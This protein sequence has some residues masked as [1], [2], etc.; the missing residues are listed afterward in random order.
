MTKAY[1]T[2]PPKPSKPYPDFPLFPPATGRWAKKIR[3][4]CVYFGPWADPDAAL[5]KYL[6]E[7]DA[8]H[9]GLTPSDTS[10]G[11]TVYQLCAK[12]LTTK[13]RMLD[14]DELSARSFNDYAATCQ[15]L[16]K[17]FGKARL[18]ADL[19]PE[20]FERLRAGMAPHCQNPI[21]FARRAALASCWEPAPSHGGTGALGPTSAVRLPGLN[22]PP[23]RR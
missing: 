3:G 1:S 11:L 19:R 14:A 8:L 13:K 21:E 12:F 6:A 18:V 4:R 22:R 7:K 2:R 9:A 5:Q 23:T 17:A 16:I 20:D 15:R 10:E